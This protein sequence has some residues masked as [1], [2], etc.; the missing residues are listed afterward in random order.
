[1]AVAYATLDSR[2]PQV[3]V[4]PEV[5]YSHGAWFAYIRVKRHGKY[6]LVL[7]QAF[8]I[9]GINDM[10]SF[11]AKFHHDAYKLFH[12]INI[13]RENPFLLGRNTDNHPNYYLDINQKDEVE[14]LTKYD[15]K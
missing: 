14:M 6:W 8:I 9:G 1:M 11:F 10:T 12:C 5:L 4:W 15:H 2:L 7:Q 3:N 13:D